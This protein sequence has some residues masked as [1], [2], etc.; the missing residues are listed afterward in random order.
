MFAKD[1]SYHLLIKTKDYEEK[2][3]IY[4]WIVPLNAGNS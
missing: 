4:V 1:K 3:T 2:S